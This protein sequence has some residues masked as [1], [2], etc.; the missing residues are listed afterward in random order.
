MEQIEIER[1]KMISTI[2]VQEDQINNLKG[3]LNQSLATK[4]KYE[5]I[6]KRLL[7]DGNCRDVVLNLLKP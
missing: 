5:N 1:E 2:T 4:L 3:L 7:E 6:F